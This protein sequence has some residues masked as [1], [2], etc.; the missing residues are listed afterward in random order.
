MVADW[1]SAFALST[2]WFAAER[3]YRLTL[4]SQAPQA[5]S[6]FQLGVSGVLRIADEAA[7]EGGRLVSQLANFALLAPP[8]SFAL[9][10]GKSWTIEIA[11]L[12]F[13][14]R[15]WTDGVQGAFLILKGGETAA[16]RIVLGGENRKGTIALV[17]ATESQI[18]V[19]PWPKSVVVTGSRPAPTALALPPGPVRKR[20]SR[21]EDL[22]FPGE[23]LVGDRGLTVGLVDAPALGPESYRID[24][25][26]DRVTLG[27]ASETGHFYGAITLLQMLRGAQAEPEKFGFPAAGVIED[28]PELAF[29][30]CHI[31]VARRFYPVG[32]LEQF[33]AVL[34]Y[35]K[36]NRLH[37]HLS[38]D[39][40]WRVEIDAF[41]KLAEMGGWR[42]LGLPLPPLLG[43]GPERSGGVFS[44]NDVRS[45]VDL[46][47]AFGIEV[48][49]EI[50]VPGHSYALLAAMPELRDP[51]ENGSYLSVQYF[52]NNCLNPAIEAT[53]PV[54][55]TILDELCALFP[56]RAVHLGAD[57]V[58][59]DAWSRSPRAN[60][61]R[62]TAGGGTGPLQAALLRR[63][64][65]MLTAR[66]KITGAWEEAAQGGGIDT[67]NS[68]LVGWRSVAASREGAAAGYDVVVAPAQAYYLDM[69]MTTEWAEPGAGWAGSSTIAETYNFAPAAG[70]TADERAH[71]IGVQ[72]CIWSE[73]MREPA[74]FDRLVFPRLS[75]V[76][77]TAWTAPAR[78]DFARFSAMAGLMPNLYGHRDG[79][80]L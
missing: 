64:Q 39:E 17:G 32:E 50:D 67:A 41:P 74:V 20:L 30:G 69:A 65:A 78:K 13:P 66:G 76:A 35:N 79:E 7:V 3:R 19:V 31:D 71:L 73:P 59:A 9:S 16:C 62:E 63:A 28:H 15:H 5:I 42:G 72:A 57:E 38:D 54:L 2:A 21:L 43:D 53:Y 37:L 44:K 23:R 46:A 45:L 10:P 25:G 4:I 56:G 14:L 55:E 48:I 1:S 22:L 80:A 47:R 36:L 26:A 58:P 68:Y 27:A 60:R 6:G 61:M 51:G 75:A 34:A 49:P 12:D 8:D 52:P 77:E 29:R 24:F 70:W 11:P 33:I 18:A 40:A